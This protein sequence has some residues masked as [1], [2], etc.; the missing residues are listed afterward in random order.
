M[1]RTMTAHE[2]S[3][4]IS[5]PAMLP[6][7]HECPNISLIPFPNESSPHHHTCVACWRKRGFTWRIHEQ[8]SKWTGTLGEE[9]MADIL[10]IGTSAG[11]VNVRGRRGG[12]GE[13]RRG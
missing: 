12:W 13:G 2:L 9:T 3:I 5:T 10:E 6:T 7:R 11:E 8:G 4:R 1:S